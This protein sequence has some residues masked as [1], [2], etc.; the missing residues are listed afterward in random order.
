VTSFDRQRISAFR[1]LKKVGKIKPCLACLVNPFTICK[2]CG[3]KMCDICRNKFWPLLSNSKKKGHKE[4][5]SYVAT[6]DKWM[7]QF[8][9]KCE[10]WP[11]RLEDIL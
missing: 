1:R 7:H 5:P 10:E 2:A 11:K 3:Y 9:T 8:A 4:A 6:G